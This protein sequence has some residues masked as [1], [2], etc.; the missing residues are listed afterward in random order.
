MLYGKKWSFTNISTL[1]SQIDVLAVVVD[2][3]DHWRRDFLSIEVAQMLQKHRNEAP[4]ACSVLIL[5]KVSILELQYYKVH[6]NQILVT[7]TGGFLI[8]CWNKVDRLDSKRKLLA[9]VES[10]CE[11]VVD[12]RPIKTKRSIPKQTTTALKTL[13]WQKEMDR[14]Q[15]MIDY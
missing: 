13:I 14:Q 1:I 4:H 5:N 15:V 12:G 6:I 11:G 3:S 9:S 10:L 2:A 8:L 7:L